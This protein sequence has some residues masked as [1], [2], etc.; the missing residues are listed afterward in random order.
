MEKLKPCPFCG[1]VPQKTNAFVHISHEIYHHKSCWLC[2][3]SAHEVSHIFK[4]S[5]DNMDVRKWNR[6]ADKEEK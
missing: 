6:R 3:H 2:S 5:H 4:H 1:A